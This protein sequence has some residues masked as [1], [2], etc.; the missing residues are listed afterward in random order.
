MHQAAV[1]SAAMLMHHC[2]LSSSPS[3]N[4]DETPSQHASTRERGRASERASGDKTRNGEVHMHEFSTAIG[5]ESLLIRDSSGRANGACAAFS[6]TA[7]RVARAVVPCMGAVT[8]PAVR[9]STL[10]G[11]ALPALSPASSS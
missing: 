7:P 6:L 10:A 2:A 1:N 3:F 8:M 4:D 5:E 9:R 11:I